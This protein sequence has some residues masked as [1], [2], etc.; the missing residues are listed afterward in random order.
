MVNNLRSFL[1][2]RNH[3]QPP[4]PDIQHTSLGLKHEI[5]H[6]STHTTTNTPPVIGI[7]IKEEKSDYI[8]VL[9]QDSQDPWEDFTSLL[10]TFGE[11][12]Q[13]DPSQMTPTQPQGTAPSTSAPSKTDIDYKSMYAKLHW[14]KEPFAEIDSNVDN[15]SPSHNL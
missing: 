7:L 4:S 3:V 8:D 13:S 5:L 10:Q 12:S 15:L 14:S 2:E 6:I 11:S 9:F 1:L